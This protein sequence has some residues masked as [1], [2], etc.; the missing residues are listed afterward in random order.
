MTE[1]WIAL[2]VLFSTGSV[3]CVVP[4]RNV[5]RWINMKNN[6]LVA[7][8]D[9]I[10]ELEYENAQLRAKQ[11]STSV[12]RSDSTDPDDL[13]IDLQPEGDKPAGTQPPAELEFNAE[14]KRDSARV[15]PSSEWD[16]S[17]VDR[18]PD[19]PVSLTTEDGTGQKL[20]PITHLDL[21]VRPLQDTL[22]TA[23]GNPTY[24]LKVIVQPRDEAQNVLAVAGGLTL[25]VLDPQRRV[26]IA[27]WEYDASQTRRWL[28][29]TPDSPGIHVPLQGSDQ[30]SHQQSLDLFVR[31]ITADGRRFE[32]QCPLRTPSALKTS[33]WS[34]RYGERERAESGVRT[35]SATTVSEAQSQID[36]LPE[37]SP[38][39]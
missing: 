28:Q 16:S 26:R 9:I 32:A 33:R 25:V 20:A 5:Q 27:R 11:S 36:R 22:R 29:E 3:G 1:R 13:K 14:P 10:A 30:W 34:R 38:R 21:E 19:R 39:R 8:E 23:N 15:V 12:D 6:E 18:V 17:L 35:A 7:Y 2:L 31:Y 37:W 24:G 4:R